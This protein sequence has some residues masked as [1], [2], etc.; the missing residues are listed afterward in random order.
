MPNN[1]KGKNPFSQIQTLFSPSTDENRNKAMKNNLND[2]QN[3]LL[4]LA[5]R[6]LKYFLL[7]LFGL[8][9]ALVVFHLFGP[10]S[11]TDILIHSQLGDWILK[12]A[13]LLFCLFAIAMIF[14]SCK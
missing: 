12:I 10:I 5:G 13:I 3:P 14:E 9:I 7:T 8:T 6:G 1:K 4:N 2:H 11:I